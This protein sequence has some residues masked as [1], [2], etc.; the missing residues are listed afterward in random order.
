MGEL[1]LADLL[2]SYLVDAEE[3][4]HKLLAQ[5]GA[6]AV[7]QGQEPDVARHSSLIERGRRRVAPLAADSAIV[8]LMRCFAQGERGVAAAACAKAENSNG[9]MVTLKTDGWVFV[10]VG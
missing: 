6:T 9:R 4:Y 7:G 8:P 2:V 10:E 1:L 3:H 5:E